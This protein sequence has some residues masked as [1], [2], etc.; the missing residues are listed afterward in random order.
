MLHIQLQLLFF[1]F[2]L[3]QSCIDE[4]Q[5]W[6]EYDTNNNM[7]VKNILDESCL[8]VCLKVRGQTLTGPFQTSG[9]LFFVVFFKSHLQLEM[10]RSSN[11]QPH[12]R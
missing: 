9:F 12:P 4:K 7:R 8:N 11:L 10:R 2:L 1:F 3:L 6:L 5:N